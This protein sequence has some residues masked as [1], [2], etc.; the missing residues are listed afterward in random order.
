MG[1]IVNY[2]SSNNMDYGTGY[3]IKQRNQSKLFPWDKLSVLFT[4]P[5][6]YR[7]CSAGDMTEKSQFLSGV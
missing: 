5:H 4:Q 2:I 3:A 7:S 1:K 6:V